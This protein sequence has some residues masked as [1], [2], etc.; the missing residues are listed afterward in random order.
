[1]AVCGGFWLGL[2]SVLFGSVQFSSVQFG[3]VWR[4]VKCVRVGAFAWHFG[5]FISLCSVLLT[6]Q[7]SGHCCGPLKPPPASLNRTARHTHRK[8]IKSSAAISDSHQMKCQM[9]FPLQMAKWANVNRYWILGLLVMAT[10][11]CHRSE[12]HKLN[13]TQQQ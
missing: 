13:Q 6:M 3:L 7:I 8:R 1:M 10:G 11:S 9:R 12:R 5:P 4:L 2:V